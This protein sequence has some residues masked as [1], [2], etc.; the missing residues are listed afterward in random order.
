VTR[1]MSRFTRSALGSDVG[2]HQG[3]AACPD[4]RITSGDPY[5]ELTGSAGTQGEQ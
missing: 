3:L 4:R 5:T 1:D 2:L